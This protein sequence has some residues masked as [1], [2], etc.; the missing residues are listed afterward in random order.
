MERLE[1]RIAADQKAMIARAA[2]LTGRTLTD[3]VVS[4]AYEAALQE[5]ERHESV[6]LNRDDSIRLAEA[7]LS[8]DKPGARLRKAATRYREMIHGG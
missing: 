2:E 4:H 5:V 8:V 3:F 1:T 7:L 6:H